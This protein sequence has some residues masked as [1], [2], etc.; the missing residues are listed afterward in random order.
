MK[1]GVIIHG[2]AWD[3]PDELVQEHI[4]GVNEACRRASSL[5]SDPEVKAVDVAEMAVILLENNPVFDAGKGSFVNQEAE[6]EMD[7]IIAT[8]GYKIGSVCAIRNIPNPVKIAR[9]V[10]EKTDHVML[11]GNGA[12]LFASE[13]GIK[14]LPAQDLLVGRELERYYAIKQKKDFQAKDSFRKN[15]DSSAMGTVGCVCLDQNGGIA[16]AVST[17]GTPFKKVGRVGDTPLWGSGAY[18][19]SSIGGVAATGYG[20]DLIRILVSKTTIEYLKTGLTIREATNRIINTLD[21]SING[22]GGVIGLTPN[23]IG[24]AFNTPRMAFAYQKENKGIISGINPEDLE[25]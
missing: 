15:K 6:V 12:N 11:A 23:S 25:A 1:F 18:M 10:M 22:L 20:E 4:K 5:L 2:G 13:M 8:D 17:G 14:E 24:L 21:S 16:V 19:E 7:A 9:Y 3:I